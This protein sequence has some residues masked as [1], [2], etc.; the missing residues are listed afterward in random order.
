MDKYYISPFDVQLLVSKPIFQKESISL[1][2]SRI[3]FQ[4][5]N[6]VVCYHFLYKG[7]MLGDEAKVISMNETLCAKWLRLI[8]GVN[9]EHQGS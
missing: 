2:L 6:G 4:V 7:F 1:G 8:I 5:V 3:R 9:I